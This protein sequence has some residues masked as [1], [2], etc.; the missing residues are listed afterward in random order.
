[1]AV[2]FPL[3]TTPYVS[4]ILGVDNIGKYSFSYTFVSYFLLL[5]GLGI[6]NYAIREGAALRAKPEELQKFVNEV[7][8]INILYTIVSYLVMFLCLASIN[9]FHVYMPIILILSVQIIFTTIG[10]EWIYSIFEDYLYITLRGIAFQVVSLVLLFV[11]VRNREDTNMYAWTTVLASVGA[12]IW[13]LITVKKYC[14]VRLILKLNIRKHIRP[15]MYIFASNVAVVIYVNSDNTILGFMTTDYNV[16][17]YSIATKIYRAIKTMLSALVVV[18]IPRLSFYIGNDMKEAFSRTLSKIF[19]LMMTFV[20]PMITGV[21]LLSEEIV[22]LISDSSYIEATSSVIILSIAT[23]FCMLSYIYGQCILM[24]LKRE[25]VTMYATI[26][27]ASVNVLLNFVLIPVFK[28]DG[29]AF[30]TVLAEGIVFVIYWIYI[31]KEVKINEALQ[32]IVKTLIGCVGIILIC[33]II[34]KRIESLPIKTVLCIIASSIIYFIVEFL[35]KNIEV[36]D[37]YKKILVKF[38]GT[39]GSV[40]K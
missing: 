26:F 35:V 36:I 15:I 5:A 40:Q 20:F 32:T 22:L 29:A 34:K 11:L 17:L 6:S 39:W 13:N 7:F 37:I 31:H 30:T 1:M 24:P 25:K 33:V 19:N 12:S 4:R 3:I 2:L 9:K 38:Q 8:S 14:K 23:L 16:G 21:I 18:S 27:S 28:Q 10:V